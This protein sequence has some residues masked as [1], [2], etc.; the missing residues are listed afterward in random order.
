MENMASTF[1]RKILELED[2]DSGALDAALFWLDFFVR[3]C[4]Y[5]LCLIIFT[6]FTNIHS[7]KRTS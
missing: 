4:A 7:F 6:T 2:K 1:F 3:V 5:H